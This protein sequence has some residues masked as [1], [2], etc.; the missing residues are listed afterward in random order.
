MCGRITQTDRY[1]PGFVITELGD[2]RTPQ[3]RYNGAPAQDF[4]VIRRHPDTGEYRSDRLIWGLIPHWNKD[5]SGGRKP[6]N[7]KGETVAN[8]ASFRWAYAKRRC[9]VPIDN[10]FE[11]RKVKPQQTKQPFAIGM[12]DGSPFALAGIWE[13]W[14]H[15]DSGEF[16]RTFCIITCSANALIDAIHDRMP[17]ILPRE[18]YDRWLSPLEPDPRDLLTPFPTEP[19]RMWPISTRVNSPTNDDP[20]ILALV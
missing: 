2:G 14:Q 6:I 17:V 20:S 4:W 16:V 12:N 5:A 18:A 19:M 1:L 9:L 8:L 3:K 15:P 11:W 10:F 7:A 13:N